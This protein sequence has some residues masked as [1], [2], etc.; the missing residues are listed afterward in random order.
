MADAEARAREAARDATKA[1][2]KQA[3][4]TLAAKGGVVRLG[5]FRHGQSGWDVV[6]SLE[7]ELPVPVGFAFYEG[8]P[9]PV[10]PVGKPFHLEDDATTGKDVAGDFVTK[11]R[12]TVAN[13]I[14]AAKIAS[15]GALKG[16]ASIVFCGSDHLRAQPTGEKCEPVQVEL[17]KIGVANEA[18]IIE[19]DE[20]RCGE[21]E[22]GA[23]AKILFNFTNM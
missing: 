12:C 4:E 1:V 16:A 18:F 10:P 6:K 14:W 3:C 19:N 23:G 7:A 9:M 21:A 15:A 20:E 22:D 17:N 8:N 13:P 11:D 2:L 5:D